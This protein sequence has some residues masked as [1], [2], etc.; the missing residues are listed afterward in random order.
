[1]TPNPH[2]RKENHNFGRFLPISPTR[3]LINTVVFHGSLSDYKM[4]NELLV[5]LTAAAHLMGKFPPPTTFLTCS[6]RLHATARTRCLII[7][8]R[9]IVL[10][11]TTLHVRGEA[12]QRK[13]CRHPADGLIRYA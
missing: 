5:T 4:I 13:E 3:I 1:M 2:D 11:K 12:M 6:K 7:M 9:Y 10:Y 8:N